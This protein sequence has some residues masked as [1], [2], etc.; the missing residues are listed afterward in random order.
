M[1]QVVVLNGTVD[2]GPRYDD[3]LS[4]RKDV[5][6]GHL[7]GVRFMCVPL[8]RVCVTRGGL[9]GLME[10]MVFLLEGNAQQW[11][12]GFWSMSKGSGGVHRFRL[13]L[14]AKLV[15]EAYCECGRCC[16]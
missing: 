14:L 8:T 11:L 12:G 13:V 5:V 3:R 10:L 1:S 9:R 15:V 2:G 4:C 16:P 6:L 7:G